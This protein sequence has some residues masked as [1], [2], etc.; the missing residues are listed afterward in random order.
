MIIED[1]KILPETDKLGIQV[2]NDLETSSC[3]MTSAPACIE[4]F[5][6][7][8]F[9]KQGATILLTFSWRGSR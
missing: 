6:H 8:K 2:F 1:S 3:L 9:G 5:I 7:T 4:L